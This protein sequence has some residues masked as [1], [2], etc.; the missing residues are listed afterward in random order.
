[1]ALSKVDRLAAWFQDRGYVVEL[2]APKGPY[3]YHL[4]M[5]IEGDHICGYGASMDEALEDL[6]EKTRQ[7]LEY[8][9]ERG[10]DTMPDAKGAA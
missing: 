4:Q 7:V 1:M 5:P 6:Q 3:P 8:L 10:A 2:H 9:A